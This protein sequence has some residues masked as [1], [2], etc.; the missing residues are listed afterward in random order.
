MNIG[1]PEEIWHIIFDFKYKNFCMK[2]CNINYEYS[3]KNGEKKLNNKCAY[4]GCLFL[5]L[6]TN[7]LF[8]TPIRYPL[9]F[10][11]K[12]SPLIV[13][14][15]LKAGAKVN[16]STI[17]GWT[18]LMY[19][20]LY[21]PLIVPDLLKAGANVNGSNDHGMTP[22]I[23]AC[24]YSPLIVPDLLKAGADVNISNDYD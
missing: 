22:L 24:Q 8:Q 18:P 20:C 4:V 3:D 23:F 11:C 9:I 15:L 10:A 1:L 19:A 16:S 5:K 7:E 21:S 12:Y 2:I 17:S 14:D 6:N 13:L